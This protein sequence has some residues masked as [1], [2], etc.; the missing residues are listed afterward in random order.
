MVMIRYSFSLKAQD[1]MV[2]TGDRRVA[3]GLVADKRM[4]EI[5][6][7]VLKKSMKAEKVSVDEEWENIHNGIT[8]AAAAVA[9][10]I[11]KVKRKPWLSDETFSLVDEKQKAYGR[12]QQN[13]SRKSLRRK[14][15]D[16]RNEVAV[17]IKKDRNQ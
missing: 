13:R 3:K 11:P 12:W 14:Y 1:E 7:K 16:L 10:K 15:Q 9:K 6:E 2:R 4:A 5:F 8:I 17:S